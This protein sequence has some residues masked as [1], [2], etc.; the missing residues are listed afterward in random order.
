MSCLGSSFRHQASS[1]ISKNCGNKKSHISF[2]DMI[3]SSDQPEIDIETGPA[4]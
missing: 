4:L 1:A 3:I 2:V